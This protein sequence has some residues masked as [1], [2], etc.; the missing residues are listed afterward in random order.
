MKKGALILLLLT[1]YATAQVSFT[2]E[3]K[4]LL[5]SYL[6]KVGPFYLAPSLF[7]R[8]LGYDDNIYYYEREKTPDWT[9]DIGV[10]FKIFS[11]FKNR[12]ILVVEEQP[13]Y[14]FYLNHEEERTIN[15]YLNVRLIT[16][17][18][19][20]TLSASYRNIYARE[21]PTSEFGHRA[22]RYA[23]EYRFTVDYKPFSPFSI[24]TYYV[25]RKINY[26]D[27]RYLFTFNL[28]KY[29]NRQEKQFGLSLYK[30][31]FTR[32]YVFL[33]F[34][35][36]QH[37]FEFKE[38]GRDSTTRMI[39][40]GL[41]LPEI[42]PIRGRF[43]YGYKELVPVDKDKPSYRGPYGRAQLEFR[44][45]RRIRLRLDY[46]RDT[47]FSFW[48]YSTFFIEE[49][50]GGGI[51]L[52]FTKRLKLGTDLYRGRM[53]FPVYQ[54]YTTDEGELIEKPRLDEFSNMSFYIAFRLLEN[55]GIGISYNFL[56]IDSSLDFFD[57]KRS[58]IGGYL[59]HD[60]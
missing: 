31:I 58:F 22:R 48:G 49:R 17:V 9:A 8:N 43:S 34:S 40:A 44:M 14:V 30:R 46:L 47:F 1:F 52:Y 23:D 42:G 57:R 33:D 7:L 3:K 20:F 29:L 2:R 11:I 55:F 59:T 13:V 36:I 32:T 10:N 25:Y 6:L 51:D 53:K 50:I 60:F 28:K 38:L 4:Y 39:S 5:K 15:N 16:Y 56:Y 35:L 12:L 45:L 37:D 41:I 24:S 27:E 54:L 21:R 26:E 18:N 19:V